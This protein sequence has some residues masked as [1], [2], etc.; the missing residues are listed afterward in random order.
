MSTP[1]S[2]SSRRKFLK[3]S[4]LSGTGAAAILGTGA[5]A[6]AGEA[7]CPPADDSRADLGGV[8]V[9]DLNATLWP[10]KTRVNAMKQLLFDKGVFSEEM[11]NGFV[12]YYT[13]VV[14]PRLGAS[15]IAHAW[16]NPQFAA[17]LTNP[18]ADEPFAATRL[19]REFLVS[20]QPEFANNTLGWSIGPEG[21]WLRVVQNGSSGGGFVHNI[22]VCTLCSC[23]P[24]A[25][26]GVQPV[27]YK[28]RQYRSRAICAPRG[29][30]REFA[31]DRPTGRFGAYGVGN[32]QAYVESYL[33]KVS[34]V[35]VWDS[36]SEARFLV[37]P[38]RPAY[39]TDAW[40]EQ[41]MA[42]LI[43]RDSMIGTDVL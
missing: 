25:L 8:P 9:S 38:S 22:V 24:Q 2:A 39:V 34:E 19:V 35:R 4:G 18:P 30:I 36:N 26:L 16:K 33:G 3:V 37:I 11:L 40:T 17:A 7:V 1:D 5:T 23:Y 6:E 27:W 21:E 43:T 31:A 42:D 29:V 10:L 12:A 41:Q 28:S 15:V 32:Y 14:T 20:R 13:E